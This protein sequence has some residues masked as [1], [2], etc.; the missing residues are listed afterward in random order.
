MGLSHWSCREGL[1]PIPHFPYILGKEAAGVI[2]G[3]PT[4]EAVLNDPEYQKRGYKE[5]ARVA[6]AAAVRL[7]LMS[8]YADPT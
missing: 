1:Y 3:L 2:T 4:D 8:C 7:I 6:A 5:G